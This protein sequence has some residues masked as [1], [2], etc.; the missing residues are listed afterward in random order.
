M[1]ISITCNDRD[2]IMQKLELFNNNEC[3]SINTIA[4]RPLNAKAK[5]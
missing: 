1:L 5:L 2:K 3:V 4:S